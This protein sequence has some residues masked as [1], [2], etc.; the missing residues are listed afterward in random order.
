MRRRRQLVRLA[1]LPRGPSPVIPRTSLLMLAGIAACALQLGAAAGAGPIRGS[2]TSTD[3]TWVCKGPVDLDSVT[4]TMTPAAPGGAAA[5]D[6]IHLASGCTGRIGRLEVTTSIADGVKVA[7][8][9]HDLTIGGGRIRC[10]AKTPL[11]HQDGIQA[12]GGSNDHPDRAHRGLRPPAGRPDQLESVREPGGRLDAAAGGRRLRLLRVRRRGRSHRQHPEL[13]AIGGRRLDPVPRAVP[14][15]DACDRRGRRRPRQPPQSRRPVQ[16][17][18]A[19]HRR[20]RGRRHVRAAA[21]PR[22]LDRRRRPAADGRRR[23]ARGGRERLHAGRDRRRG[24][25]RRRLAAHRPPRRPDRVPHRGGRRGRARPRWSG[26][27]A[28]PAPAAQGPARRELRSRAARC[29]GE[30]W[31]SSSR[32]RE[33]G[34]RSAATGSGR[35]P[36]SRSGRASPRFPRA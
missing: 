10:L 2:V 13:G 20:G 18:A 29:A 14:A 4:V 28:P 15:A 5:T 24:R 12:M 11:L 26:A 16:R 25:G 1:P 9:V 31:C 3:K 21:R 27:A 32:R 36:P 17:P 7:Q 23:G 6:A 33:A 19:E 8:G 22:R 35:S 34:S 30:R